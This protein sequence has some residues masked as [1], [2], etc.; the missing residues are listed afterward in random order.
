M[1]NSFRLYS[2]MNSSYFDLISG[3]KETQQTKGLGLLLSKSQTALKAFLD[4]NSIKSKIGEIDLKS[5]SRV[6]VNCEL[7]SNSLNK[8]RA[9][10]VLRFYKDGQP[11]KAILIE[12]KSINKGTSV[13]DTNKQIEN[14][15]ENEVFQELKVFRNNS[16]G[17]TLTKLPSYTKH[18][19]LVSITWEDI[20]SAFYEVL[21]K[22]NTLLDD[23]FSFLTNINGTM[24][25][26]EKEVF[27]IPT[28]KWSEQAIDELKVYECPNDGKYLIKH[29]PLYITFRKSGGGEM[30]KLFKVEEII[31]L[32]F[33]D[34]FETFMKDENYSVNYRDRVKGYVDY[35]LE[36]KIWVELPKDEKQ[37]FILSDNVIELKNRPRP[38]NGNNSFRAYYELAD[39]LNKEL[40]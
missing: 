11:F 14:Y 16:L 25:F 39:L 10:I 3:D 40:V 37:V 33:Y 34:D 21:P 15:I 12:A 20:I 19:S 28:A 24:K 26:Y 31:I 13:Y 35:L 38:K 4:I 23:Y 6:I 30:D 29:K 27:S 18:A 5:I 22:Q 1:R 36:N 7:I 2:S 8:Y 17:V 32:N 9:D